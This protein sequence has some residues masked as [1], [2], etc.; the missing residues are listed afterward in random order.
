MR[1]ILPGELKW[2]EGE[3]RLLSLSC[4]KIYIT[5]SNTAINR[6]FRTI[7]KYIFEASEFYCNSFIP[8][9]DLEVKKFY[10]IILP[11]KSL[12]YII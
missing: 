4:N 6:L 5:D 12:I 11:K 8:L 3:D 1:L 7:E 10:S 9:L 2:L